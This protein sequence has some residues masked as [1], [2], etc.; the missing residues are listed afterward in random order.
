MYLSEVEK[1]ARYLISPGLTVPDVCKFLVLETF[2]HLKTSAV[3]ASEITEDGCLAPVGTFGLNKTVVT[4]WGNI[5]LTIEAPLTVS[6]KTNQL[7]LI[8]R[9]EAIE[10]YPIL[11]EYKGIP[12]KWDSY[13]VTPILPF[14]AIALTLD[15]VPVI[16]PELDSFLRAV[17][18]LACLFIQRSQVRVEPYSRKH[19]VS[20]SRKQGVLTERQVLI[21]Q[22]MEKGHTNTAIAEEIGYSESLVRQETMAIYATLNISGRKE[23]LDNSGGGG[24]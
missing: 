12:E 24:G 7:V 1:L 10:R 23:L 16:E 21:K 18:A 11:V 19:S 4:A 6:V 13:L 9:E 3:Y 17:G 8:R 2:A 22:L 14:G 15:S 20:K 5:P